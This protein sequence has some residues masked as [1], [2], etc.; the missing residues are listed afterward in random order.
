MSEVSYFKTM[1]VSGSEL[2]QQNSCVMLTCILQ[3]ELRVIAFVTKL[4]TSLGLL[5]KVHAASCVQSSSYVVE[6]DH[7]IEQ[8][9]GNL[10]F[11]AYNSRFAFPSEESG[12]SSSLFYSFNAG[13][14]HFVM[15]GAYTSY[16]KSGDQYN[17]LEKDLADVD[18]NVTPWLVA[19]WHPPWYSTYMAHYREAECMR[20]E[21]EDILYEYGVDIVF[22]GHVHAYERSNRVYNYTLDPCGPVYITVGDG[23]GKFCWDQQPEYSAYRESSFGHGL[24]EVRNETHALWTW[25]RN[26][27]LYN[28]AGDQIYIVRQPDMCPV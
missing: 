21:L 26:Q 7:E 4:I 10:T 5:G 28:R 25:H 8:Q 2:P 17:W 1:P 20:V 3:M 16:D 14:I 27:D 22:N 12:S 19:A 24:L 18:R 23:A 13:G 9:A 15:L 6:G 11:A